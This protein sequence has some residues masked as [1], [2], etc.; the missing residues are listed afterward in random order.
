VVAVGVI[1]S[2]AGERVVVMS[3]GRYYSITMD[4]LDAAW[5]NV[6]GIRR[7][8]IVCAKKTTLMSAQR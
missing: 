6:D 4:K 8:S 7:P 5:R 2:G 3:W 1:G